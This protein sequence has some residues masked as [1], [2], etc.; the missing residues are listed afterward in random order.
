MPDF[1]EQ[2]WALDLIRRLVVSPTLDNIRAVLAWVRAEGGHFHNAATYNPLNT[3]Y[4]G[5][6][7]VSAFG[8]H[9]KAY[10]S[11]E[12]GMGAT[13]ATITR[14]LDAYGYRAIVDALR[15]GNDGQAVLDAIDRSSWGTHHPLL[16]R[17]YDSLTGVTPPVA[18][19][20]DDWS[21]MLPLVAG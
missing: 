4:D 7:G 9:I 6:G 2:D 15:A 19:P 18:T 17:V 14:G 20:D 16:Q 11:Y 8:T 10:P 21:W 5:F 1:T 12:D 13:V 3:S